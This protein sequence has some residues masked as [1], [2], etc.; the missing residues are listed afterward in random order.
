MGAVD[1]PVAGQALDKGASQV[2]I[3]KGVGL[4]PQ[5]DVGPSEGGI[6]VAGFQSA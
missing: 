3:F 1:L 4:F 2:R 6:R 5:E